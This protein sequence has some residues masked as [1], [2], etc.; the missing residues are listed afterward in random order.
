[1]A[2]MRVPRQTRPACDHITLSDRDAD[3]SDLLRPP[4]SPPNGATRQHWQSCIY[5]RI[6]LDASHMSGGIMTGWCESDA[7]W[8]WLAM[9][10]ISS[11]LVRHMRLLT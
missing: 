6:L 1:M 11:D 3:L 9:C 7:K 5:R 2:K 10:D 4:T 8:E